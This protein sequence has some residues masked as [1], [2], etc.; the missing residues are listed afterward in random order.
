MQNSLLDAL[1]WRYATKRYD[2]S[3]KIP[4]ATFELLV[5]LNQRNGFSPAGTDAHEL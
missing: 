4:Q 2:P 5:M 3:R 1:N